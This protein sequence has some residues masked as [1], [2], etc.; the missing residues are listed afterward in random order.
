MLLSVGERTPVFLRCFSFSH[1]FFSATVMGRSVLGEWIVF[2][3]GDFLI[4]Q[5]FNGL[6][7]CVFFGFAYGDGGSR[8]TGPS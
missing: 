5:L 3:D 7:V 1:S 6:D 2:N 8:F 4:D